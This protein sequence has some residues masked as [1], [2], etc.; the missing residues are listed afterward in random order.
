MRDVQE[1]EETTAVKDVKEW[2]DDLISANTM[3]N[4]EDPDRA[5]L[6]FILQLKGNTFRYSSDTEPIF[7]FGSRTTE[8]CNFAG[9]CQQSAASLDGGSVAAVGGLTSMGVK[10]VNVGESRM[11]MRPLDRFH[12][13]SL[14]KSENIVAFFVLRI[15]HGLASECRHRRGGFEAGK[16]ILVMHAAHNQAGD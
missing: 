4:N 3:W 7:C 10:P 16:V 12:L 9:S 14:W 2:R 5:F 15:F 6:F 13:F 8:N 1:V 11:M